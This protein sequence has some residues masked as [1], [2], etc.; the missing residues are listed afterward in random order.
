[1]DYLSEIQTLL[2]S[3]PAAPEYIQPPGVSTDVIDAFTKRT[4]IA[5]PEDLQVWLRHANGLSIGPGGLYGIQ[6]AR[7]GLDIEYHYR[8]FPQ[9]KVKCWIPIAGDGNGNYYILDSHTGG[10][11]ILFVDVHEDPDLPT[12]IVASNIWHFLAF[13]LK[14]ELNEPGWPFRR[15]YVILHD[16]SIIQYL[17]VRM[18]WEPIRVLP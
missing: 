13:L 16:P 10:N 8:I 9:W 12:F 3:V 14:R 17:N 4:N 11:P 2:G 7:K 15:E 1:M 6:T 5:V 18:P